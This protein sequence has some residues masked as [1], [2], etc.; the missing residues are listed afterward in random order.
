MLKIDFKKMAHLFCPLE[1]EQFISVNF[2]QLKTTDVMRLRKL[3]R[4][5]WQ[6]N[7]DF[8]ALLNSA[9][10]DKKSI[11]GLALTAFRRMYVKDIK[12]EEI[13]DLPEE[14]YTAF[15][16]CARKIADYRNDQRLGTKRINR[17]WSKRKNLTK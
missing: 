6:D 1:I 7:K 14:Q 10:N 5:I 11:M 3:S 9:F 2:F 17:R 12:A 16:E 4:K 8:V 13:L 15:W